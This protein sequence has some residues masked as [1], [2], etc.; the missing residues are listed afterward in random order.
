MTT[1]LRIGT[2]GSP[3]AL[4]QAR[5]VAARLQAPGTAVE[6]VPIRTEGD[7]LIEARLAAVGGK[8]LFVREIEQALLA[9][10]VD[11]A[12]H[13]LKDLPAELPAGLVLTA[14]PPREDPGDVLV[15]RTD[16]G[17]DALSAGAVVG[18]SSPRR[19]ALVLALRP[20]L[21]VEPIRG[22]VDT[23]LRKLEGGG[24]DGVILAAAGLRRLGL[25]PRH[26][27]PLDPAVFVPAVGQ[28]IV[29]I[30]TCERDGRVRELLRR[31]DHATTH[32]CALAERAYLARLGAS[33]N[34]PM[35]GHA[36][37]TEGR[38]EMTGVVAS[39]D[40]KQLLRAGDAGPA[41][42]AEALGRRLADALL[43]RGA[44]SVAALRP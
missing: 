40:G 20:D 13:S 19:R 33:C 6:I 26:A 32:A 24:F 39:E 1:R 5:A 18:T 25:R 34:S 16:G 17:L 37:P 42:E 41:T 43:A 11:C 27:C 38:L 7:R 3:L 22:N 15:T 8:G 44:A 30:E 4:A 28:G 35:A 36:R 14:F 29:A 23:R 10:T 12:V 2:R 21:V 9:G 31:L